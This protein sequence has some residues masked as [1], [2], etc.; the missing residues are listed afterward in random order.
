MLDDPDDLIN[1]AHTESE[2]QEIVFSDNDDLTQS[3]SH[4]SKLSSTGSIDGSSILAEHNRG[5]VNKALAALNISPVS[6]RKL[7]EKEYPNRK[8]K[9]VADTVKCRLKI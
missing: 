7:K 8:V 9:E 4:A 3:S 1:S 5:A 6:K 2:A